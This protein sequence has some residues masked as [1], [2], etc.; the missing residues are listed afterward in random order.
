MRLYLEEG[1]QPPAVDYFYKLPK[2]E[3]DK[4]VQLL[5]ALSDVKSDE[6]RRYG[7]EYDLVPLFRWCFDEFDGRSP[8]CSCWP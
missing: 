4:R 5:A 7:R 8:N 6:L 2:A 1:E 3:R